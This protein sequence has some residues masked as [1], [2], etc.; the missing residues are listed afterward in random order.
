MD[1]KTFSNPGLN[2]DPLHDTNRWRNILNKH[3]KLIVPLA[4][5]STGSLTSLEICFPCPSLLNEMRHDPQKLRSKQQ[6]F[7][8][9]RAVPAIIMRN[10]MFLDNNMDELSELVKAQRKLSGLTEVLH[11]AL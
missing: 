3:C 7:R 11:E 10:G 2:L 8:V 9:V 5:N 4:T 1:V 6:G